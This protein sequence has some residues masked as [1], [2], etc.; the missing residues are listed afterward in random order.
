LNYLRRGNQVDEIRTSKQVLRDWQE[1][2]IRIKDYSN[3]QNL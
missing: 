2:K 3:S 1:G